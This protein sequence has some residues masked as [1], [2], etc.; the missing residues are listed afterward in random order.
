MSNFSKVAVLVFGLG[1]L[2]V[3]ALPAD[4]EVELVSHIEAIDSQDSPAAGCIAT[5]HLEIAA[6]V[7]SCTTSTIQ[8]VTVPAGG[9]I[10]L[11]GL[12]GKTVREALHSWQ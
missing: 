11:S 6:I 9:Q 4:R 10:R 2:L 12:Q 8:G 3:T 5:S 1:S 7:A